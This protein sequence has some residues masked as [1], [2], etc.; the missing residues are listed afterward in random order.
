MYAR[1]WNRFASESILQ[2]LSYLNACIENGAS[3][4]GAKAV[5]LTMI[6]CG[7]SL[8]GT[9][10]QSPDIVAT[11]L[12]GVMNAILTHGEEG[13]IRLVAEGL[14]RFCMT[15][16]DAALVRSSLIAVAE[17]IV[18]CSS[19][20]LGVHTVSSDT[21][22]A[23]SSAIRVVLSL[24]VTWSQ[25]IRGGL[26]I[27]VMI[28]RRRRLLVQVTP[29][30]KARIHSQMY[31]RESGQYSQAFRRRQCADLTMTSCRP[32]SRCI[33]LCLAVRPTSSRPILQL[34]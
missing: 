33:P 26:Q 30:T 19:H 13:S 4:E 8:V 12:T 22:A 7:K 16:P 24:V 31:S 2:V 27:F 5:R 1:V 11:A 28:I 25:R 34:P 23:R 29:A 9:A 32:V 20:S 15:M 10:T 6:G 14:T 21:A 17:P 3:H 18:R